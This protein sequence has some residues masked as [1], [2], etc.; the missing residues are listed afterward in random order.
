MTSRDITNLRLVNQ[1]L[2]GSAFTTS[3]ELVSWMGCIQSQEFAGAKWAIGNRL[4]GI[5]DADIEND[6]NAGKILRTHIL[7]PTWHFVSPEDICWML[8]LTAPRIK[9]MS[10][11]IHRKLGINDII[12]KRSKRIIAEALS[13]GKQLTR[14]Q[15]LPFFKENRINTDD[16]RLGF[17][18][19]DAELDG[20]ICSG[21]RLG[22]QF[23]YALLEERVLNRIQINKEAA[24][25]ELAKRYFLSRGPATLQDF[26]WWSGLNLTQSKL[27]LELNKSILIN[28]VINGQAYWFSPSLKP[29]NSK[30]LIKL[31]PAFDEYAISYK[32]RSDILSQPSNKNAGNGIFKPIIVIDGKIQG[33]WTRSY[34]KRHVQLEIL[35]LDSSIRL[36]KQQ[37]ISASESYS[38]FLAT[39]VNL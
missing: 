21:A 30:G 29:A 4:N 13:G 28:E 23:T 32:D 8:K 11:G 34:L 19:M 25:A 17:L 1:Q 20:L 16:I 12:L 2:T 33:T 31:L 15:L 10:K 14:D 26:S 9:A 36:L 39:E 37:L 24:L 38:R 18:L 35:A 27:A 5:T 7:R 22:K 3:A 6:F